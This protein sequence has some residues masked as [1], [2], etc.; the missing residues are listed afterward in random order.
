MISKEIENYENAWNNLKQ[1][2]GKILLKLKEEDQKVYI[3][4]ASN[5]YI[6][7]YCKIDEIGPDVVNFIT[8]DKPDDGRLE[9][10]NILINYEEFS[11]R[12][13]CKYKDMDYWDINVT[14]NP[15]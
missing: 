12:P 9:N 5:D 6:C 2:L 1:S 14:T 7:R 10:D 15:Y 3:N 4:D 13:V 11:I 8:I